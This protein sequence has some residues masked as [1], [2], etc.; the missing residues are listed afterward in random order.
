M[1]LNWLLIF[2]H[3]ILNNLFAFYYQFHFFYNSM[4]SC[5]FFFFFFPKRRQR[6]CRLLALSGMLGVV[7]KGSEQGLK[8]IEHWRLELDKDS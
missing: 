4:L 7:G 8:R 1:P 6:L 5:A 3:L 2:E